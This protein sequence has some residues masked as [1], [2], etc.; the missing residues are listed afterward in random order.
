MKRT[1]KKLSML[2]AAAAMTVVFAACSDDDK[3]SI[4][5]AEVDLDRTEVGQLSPS[6]SVQSP[7][8]R[9]ASAGSSPGLMT[10]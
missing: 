4:S 1:I 6:S 5:Q 7:S 10:A 2:M 3:Y 9:L 8:G